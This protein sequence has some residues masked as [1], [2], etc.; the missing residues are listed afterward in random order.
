M[1]PYRRSSARC[2]RPLELPGSYAD[3]RELAES[4]LSL[5][6]PGSDGADPTGLRPA[7]SMIEGEWPPFD[8]AAGAPS[9]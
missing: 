9:R 7:E 6:E 1:P 2:L 3:L 5:P 8:E 4:L